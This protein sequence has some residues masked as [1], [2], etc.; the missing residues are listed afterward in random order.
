MPSQKLLKYPPGFNS[1]EA[2]VDELHQ[3]IYSSTVVN[4]DVS[5]AFLQ[6]SSTLFHAYFFV[7][8]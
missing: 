4:K 3:E 1:G 5:E 7:L 8:D 6:L 2:F